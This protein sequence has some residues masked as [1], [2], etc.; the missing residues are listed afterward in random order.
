M[1]WAVDC[2]VVHRFA[3]GRS[4]DRSN[5]AKVILFKKLYLRV[6]CSCVTPIRRV[7]PAV[8]HTAVV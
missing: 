3:N 4:T 7:K 8:P 2:I 6:G 5:A 1:V